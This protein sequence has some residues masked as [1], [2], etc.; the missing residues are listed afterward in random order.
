MSIKVGTDPVKGIYTWN[1]STSVPVKAVYNGSSKIFPEVK[2]GTVDVLIVGGGGGCMGGGADSYQNSIGGGGAGGMVELFDEE[3]QVGRQYDIVIG[4]GGDGSGN[5]TKFGTWQAEKGGGVMTPGGSGGGELATKNQA[6][7]TFGAGTG[8]PGQGNDG[9]TGEGIS[10]QTAAGGGGGAGGKGQ[11]GQTVANLAIGGHGGAP[12]MTTIKGHNEV[13]CG[14]GGGGASTMFASSGQSSMQSS[15]G[16][17]GAGK[18]GID[19]GAGENAQPNT[20][21]GGGCGGWGGQSLP[22]RYGGSGIVVVTSHAAAVRT[23]GAPQYNVSGGR[24]IYIYKGSGSI[25][26]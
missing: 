20:G 25:T 5:P 17:A 26:F 16:G 8:T 2:Q 3:L 22:P 6:A 13:Y 9:G 4:A 1:G 7:G 24:H 18:G 23:T 14:G 19:G 15:G 10:N 12:K 11:K 21:S